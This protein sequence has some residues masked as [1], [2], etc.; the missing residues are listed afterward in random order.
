MTMVNQ[1]RIPI[2][3]AMCRGTMAHIAMV[4]SNACA[5]DPRVLRHASWLVKDGHTVEVHAF[6]RQ[7]NHPHSDVINGVHILRYHGMKTPYGGL[8]NTARGLRRF[9]KKVIHELSKKPPDAVYCHDADT[10]HIGCVL[11]KKNDIN[12]IFDMHDLHHT[13][14]RMPNPDS[15]IRAFIADRLENR[16]LRHISMADLIYTSSGK[17][18][19]NTVHDGFREYLLKH[20][21]QSHVIENRPQRANTAK[22]APLQSWCVGYLGRVRDAKAFDLL[23]ESLLLMSVEE[24]PT[25]RIAGDGTAT[26]A[27][28]ALLENAQR[29][30]GILSQ[31]TG[32]YGAE[33]YPTLIQE[34]DVMFAM[35][36]PERGNIEHGALPVKMFDAAAYGVPSVVNDDCLMGEVATTEKLGTAVPWMNSRKL[37]DA[38][39]QLRDWHVEM[40]VY[41]EHEKE[42][43]LSSF[44]TL[45]LL[46]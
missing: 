23:I 43:F 20:G 13:W 37:S 1:R 10:L 42:K 27:V 3:V 24:R 4:V 30:Y 22:K 35:Y 28:S 26:K 46:K 32:A 15:R 2:V 12:L 41:A 45:G 9:G 33:D 14:V 25:L 11:K 39:L 40:F 6:D 31:I 7:Q 8:L 34:I 19:K 18:G 16:M 5:P 36:Q 29:K 17:I 44:Q 21:I 38:L